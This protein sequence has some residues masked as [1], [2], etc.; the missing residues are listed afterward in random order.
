MC[1]DICSVRTK[2]MMLSPDHPEPELPWGQTDTEHLLDN[3]H[4]LGEG[5]ACSGHVP[6]LSREEKRRRRRKT[7]RYRSAH[8]TRER[9]RVVAFN[10]AFAELR[11]LLPT[12]P[13]DKKLSKIDILRLAICYI[14]YLNHVLDV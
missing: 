8:A 2:S 7:A 11:K 12:I 10:V 5:R 9:V 14:S 4:V 6:T 3:V 1:K 13:P